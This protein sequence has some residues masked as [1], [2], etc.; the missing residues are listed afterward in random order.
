MIKKRHY[1]PRLLRLLYILC[2]KELNTIYREFSIIG[3][4]FGTKKYNSIYNSS[5]QSKELKA[6][7]RIPIKFAFITIWFMLLLL[8]IWGVFAPLDSAAIAQGYVTVSGNKKT[9]QH[10]EGGIISEI[11]AR[12][13]DFVHEGDPLIR[14]NDTL[15]KAKVQMALSKLRMEYAALLRLE[16]E[17][18]NEIEPIFTTHEQFFDTSDSEVQNLI[19]TQMDLFIAKRSVLKHTTDI[20]HQRILQYQEMIKGLEVQ[21]DAMQK[22][23]TLLKEEKNNAETLYKKGLLA[24]DRLHNI[25]KNE[26]EILAR[27]GDVAANIAKM[28]E[29]ISEAKLQLLKVQSDYDVEVNAQIKEAQINYKDMEEQYKAVQDVL[30]RMI[31]R[32]PISGIVNGMAYHT[33]GGVIAPGGKIMD[34]IPQDAKLV[35]EAS[36][37]P[38]DIE[39]LK[40]GLQ[41]RIQ[42]SAYKTRLVPRINGHVTYISADRV[43][44]PQN[45]VMPYHYTVR[46]EIDSEEFSKMNYDVKL[47]PGMPADVYIVKGERT[48]AQYIISPIIE[49]FHKAFKEA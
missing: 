31:I 37:A 12:D 45:P 36:V 5:F 28:L 10:Q 16:A 49:S 7:I 22:Q 17:K 2:I 20:V 18:N 44:D 43:Q 4:L 21:K 34:I 47:Y 38:R 24:Q 11:I 42:L 39:S 33:V 19:K 40:I 30:A 48:F 15:S 23:L 9:V 1:I 26:Q 46:I 29:S 6:S 13:G 25:M 27:L 3:E 41:A 14:L 8:I 32:A 35:I